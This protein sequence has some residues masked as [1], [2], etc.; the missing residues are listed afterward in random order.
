[1]AD[2]TATD[3]TGPIEKPRRGRPP[4]AKRDPRDAEIA[5]LKAALAEAKTEQVK[6]LEIAPALLAKR[7]PGEYMTVG[8]DKITGNPEIRKRP[9][10]RGD[11]DVYPK[12]NYT[13]AY[14]GPCVVQGVR[15]DMIAGKEQSVPSVVKDEY[16]R[17]MRIQHPDYA[18]QYPEPSM[19]RIQQIN[20]QARTTKK[21]A[22]SNVHFIGTGHVE[23]TPEW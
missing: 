19:E 3:G 8:Q 18:A 20:Q 5:R 22:W 6:E 9:W 10:I 16:E 4:K 13:P 1:M 23:S 11:F 15:F 14:S 2:E 17:S 7:K 12:V 21:P